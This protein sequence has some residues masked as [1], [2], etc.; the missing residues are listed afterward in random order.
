MNIFI[1]EMNREAE[2]HIYGID[3]NDHTKDFMEKFFKGE[4]LQ[5]LSPEEREK[6]S[7]ECEYAISKKN[8]EI[9][10]Q[11]IEY[12]QKAI[13]TIAEDV[14]RSQCD[15]HKEYTFESGCFVV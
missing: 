11:Q 8:F 1:I 13:D 14:K 9:I 4:G 3:N 15:P 12:I 7:T 6:Y 2:I 10:A 5:I